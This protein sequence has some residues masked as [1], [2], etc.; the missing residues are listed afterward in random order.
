MPGRARRGEVANRQSEVGEELLQPPGRVAEVAE[1][2]LQPS[3]FD[4]VIWAAAWG[5]RRMG[6]IRPDSLRDEWAHPTHP[7]GGFLGLGAW[8]CSK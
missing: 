3:A 5:G 1:P 8:R 6:K 7:K 2:P 4:P